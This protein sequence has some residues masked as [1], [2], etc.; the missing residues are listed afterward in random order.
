MTHSN[1]RTELGVD[2]LSCGSIRRVRDS[3]IW[4]HRIGG[5]CQE[6]KMGVVKGVFSLLEFV[7]PLYERHDS[8]IWGACLLHIR[9]TC[10]WG[11]WLIPAT[12]R[13]VGCNTLQHTTTHGNTR[14]HTA[15]HCNTL[16]HT[17]THKNK[18]YEWVMS[19]IRMR[20]VTHMN[21]SCHIDETWLRKEQ[22]FFFEKYT[23]FDKKWETRLGKRKKWLGEK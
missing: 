14:Q 2:R 22:F 23:W 20:H 16:Q 13:A 6:E 12:L 3:F 7:T 18:T 9:D 4:S 10:I 11:T 17:A 21:K 5:W 19:H 15:I 8:F 1:A